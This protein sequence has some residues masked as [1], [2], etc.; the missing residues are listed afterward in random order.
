MGGADE[1]TEAS[2]KMGYI[3]FDPVYSQ[4]QLELEADLW[5]QAAIKVKFNRPA[6]LGG[7]M[8]QSEEKN[9]GQ[10]GIQPN[11]TAVTAGRTE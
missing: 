1:H 4:E 8:T 9:T 2:A 5:N 6:E 3:T 11:E 10:T 7:L